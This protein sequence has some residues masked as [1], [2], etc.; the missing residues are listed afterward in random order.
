MSDQLMDRSHFFF[1]RCQTLL[2]FQLKQA[3]GSERNL[4]LVILWGRNWRKLTVETRFCFVGGITSTSICSIIRHHEADGYSA[5]PA[6]ST[7]RSFFLHISLAGRKEKKKKLMEGTAVGVS[8]PL[9]WP[10]P[11]CVCRCVSARSAIVCIFIRI[12]A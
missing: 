6:L 12:N 2:S 3:M 4:F 7:R 5:R 10:R 9:R 11:A 1:D 8:D